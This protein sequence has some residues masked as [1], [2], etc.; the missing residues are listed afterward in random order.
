[1]AQRKQ[2]SWTEMRVGLFV[3]A[4]LVILLVAIFFVTGAEHP[5]AEV[6][7][8]H[9]SAGGRGSADGRA[10]GLDGVQIGNVQSVSLTPHP[11]D[12]MHNITLVLRIDKK[13]QDRSAPIR[14]FASLITQGLLGD[15]Y[16]TITR[17]LTGTV[18]ARERH[19]ARHGGGRDE[20]DRRARR[21]V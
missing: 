7:S 15:R 6:Q 16:V 8:H 10:R 12:R 5:R 20:A 21:R 2:L 3:L 18:I 9:L 19:R 1:M 17:G 13:Y 11:Q 14:I 4:G